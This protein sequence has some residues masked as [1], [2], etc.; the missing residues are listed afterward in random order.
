MLVSAKCIILN[1][2]VNLGGTTGIFLP[3]HCGREVF[4]CKEQGVDE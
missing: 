3:S 4:V 2:M 1:W